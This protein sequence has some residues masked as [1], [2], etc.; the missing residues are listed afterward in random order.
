MTFLAILLLRGLRRR[1]MWAEVTCERGVMLFAAKDVKSVYGFGCL[2]AASIAFALAA[3]GARLL[4][5]PPVAVSVLFLYAWPADILI[6]PGYVIARRWWGQRT[7]IAWEDVA[8]VVH[9]TGDHST[10]VFSNHGREIR[11]SGFHASPARFQAECKLRTPVS[12][13]T[14]WDAVPSLVAAQ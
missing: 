3:A 13:I 1:A 2:L 12:H 8:S 7:R 4:L 11:H 10:F 9:R 5:I 14:D 6:T